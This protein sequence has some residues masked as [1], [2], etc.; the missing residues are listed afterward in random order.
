MVRGRLGLLI[1]INLLF[2]GLTVS[3]F[4]TGLI[5]WYHYGK[6]HILGYKKLLVYLAIIFAVISA[7]FISALFIHYR[8][9]DLEIFEVKIALRI[10][11]FILGFFT[12]ILGLVLGYFFFLVMGFGVVGVLSAF[13]RSHTPPLLDQIKNLNENTSQEMKDKD[14]SRYIFSKAVSWVFDVPSYLETTTL[15]VKKPEDEIYFPKSKFKTALV[16]EIFFCVIL[17]INISLNP[18]LLQHFSLSQLFG[19]TS[20]I[21]IFTPLI[22]LPWFIYLKLEVEIEAPAKNF[23]LYEGL[24]R[25]VLSLLVALGTII[26]FVRLS[27]ERINLQVFLMSFLVYLVSILILTVLFTF[28]YFN[29][30]WR[31]LIRDIYSEYERRF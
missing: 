9:V 15:K 8:G 26:T 5:S 24:K 7:V 14:F 27:F 6:N 10:W 23:R 30:Y 3:F 4:F 28:V 12:S 17:A 21:A 1:F 13:L 25:R 2:N 20:S 29:H 18:I 22:V 31:D 16:W 11:T 19:I